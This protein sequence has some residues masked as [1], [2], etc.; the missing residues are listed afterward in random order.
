MAQV[1]TGA[2]VEQYRTDGYTLAGGIFTPAELDVLE[3]ELDELMQRRLRNAAPMDATWQGDWKDTLAAQSSAAG[4]FSA[5]VGGGPSA[6][7][8]TAPAAQAAGAATAVAAPANR[9]APAAAAPA[10]R[11]APAVAAPANRAVPAVAAQTAPAVKTELLHTHDVQAYSAAWARVLTHERFTAAL[12]DL[13][14]PNVALHHTKGFLKPPERGSAFPMHQDYP[15]FPHTLGTMLAAIIHLSDATEEMGCFRVY[16]GTHRRGPLPVVNDQQPY[17]DPHEWP[18]AGAT[19]VPARRGDVVFFSY[20][21]VHGSDINRSSRTRK[22][23]LVQVRDAADHPQY[24]HRDN[25]HALGLILRGVNPLLNGETLAA[26][27][28][29]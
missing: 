27:S 13:L 26:G 16:P 12:A 6:G 8:T 11:A 19:P 23:V 1:L 29:T 17:V 5:P 28:G 18:I 14:G 3:R 15:Y 22:T 10:N 24:T 20:L 2:Q 7:R 9:A 4:Q 25:S 21:L